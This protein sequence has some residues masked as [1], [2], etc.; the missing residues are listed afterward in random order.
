MFDNKLLKRVKQPYTNE[1]VYAPT[2][3]AYKLSNLPF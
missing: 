3:K 1:Y 2:T